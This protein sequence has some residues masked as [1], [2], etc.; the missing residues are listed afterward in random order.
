MFIAVR[1][2]CISF[3]HRSV[4]IWFHIFPVIIHH[5]EG[6]FEIF[7]G[8][9]AVR[10]F[11]ERLKRSVYHFQ[12]S[13]SVLEISMFRKI[14]E[15]WRLMTWLVILCYFLV[16][17]FI[18]LHGN[19]PSFYGCNISESST[20]PQFLGKEVLWHWFSND[21]KKNQSSKI[22]KPLQFAA[23]CVQQRWTPP[24]KTQRWKK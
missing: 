23:L 18:V 9:K 6:L 13:V 21:Q 2:A 17:L 22:I 4:H 1:I 12:T 3:L 5:L 16:L 15:M 19:Q 7:K 10:E 11:Q 20:R 24:S 14:S 8:I